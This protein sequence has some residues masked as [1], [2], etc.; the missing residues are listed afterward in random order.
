MGGGEIEAG[1][2]AS[3]RIYPWRMVYNRTQGSSLNIL[4]STRYHDAILDLLT[5]PSSLPDPSEL[6]L[7]FSLCAAPTP[8]LSHQPHCISASL[9]LPQDPELWYS[10]PQLPESYQVLAH[11][12]CSI[13][14]FWIALKYAIVASACSYL[15]N[16]LKKSCLVSDTCMIYGNGDMWEPGRR[17]PAEWHWMLGQEMSFCK[18]SFP[19]T[20]PAQLSLAPSY[21]Q[22]SPS[23]LWPL[24]LVK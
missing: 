10:P 13:N 24:P 16:E 12:C 19:L 1:E 9:L 2:G 22:T 21:L 7:Y 17:D 18:I 3:G 8:L 6:T 15:L 4:L 20:S 5:V 23:P 11:S 14:N